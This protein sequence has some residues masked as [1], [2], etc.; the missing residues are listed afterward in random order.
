MNCEAQL[1]AWKC[2][3]TFFGGRSRPVK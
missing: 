1:M 2:L 3:F